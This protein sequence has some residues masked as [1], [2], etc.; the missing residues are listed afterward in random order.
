MAAMQIQVVVNALDDHLALLLAAVVTIKEAYRDF[1][2]I[3][4]RATPCLL[5]GSL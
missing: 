2:L 4:C 3:I 5:A 1:S